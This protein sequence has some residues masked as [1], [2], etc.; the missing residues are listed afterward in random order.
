VLKHAQSKRWRD[1]GLATPDRKLSFSRH[2]VK[3]QGLFEFGQA[4]VALAVNS[5]SAN[6]RA[7]PTAY[8]VR[9]LFNRPVGR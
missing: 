6:E 3:C 5:A 2:P 7:P 4:R 9:Y 1:F 8:V